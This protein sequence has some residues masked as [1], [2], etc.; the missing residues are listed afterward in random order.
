MTSRGSSK[1]KRSP[2][3]A[4]K[5][6]VPQEPLPLIQVGLGLFLLSAASLAFEVALTHLFS[7]VFQYHFAFLAISSAILG[8]GMGAILRYRLPA[9][10]KI[11]DWLSRAAGLVALTM[12][13]AVILFSLL[14][15]APGIVVHYI[16]QESSLAVRF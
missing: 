8:L 3:A 12:S 9:T 10:G 5:R 13:L 6:S 7:L 16:S 4:D 2:A 15:F 11:Q 14:G 1:S